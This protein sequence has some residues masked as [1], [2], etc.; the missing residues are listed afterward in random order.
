M[1]AK[2]IL[3]NCLSDILKIEGNTTEIKIASKFI[4]LPCVPTKGMW[5]N[6]KS[7]KKELNLTKKEIKLIE[8]LDWFTITEIII[9]YSFIELLITYGTDNSE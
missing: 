2:L 3:N 5:F 8:E 4:T 6:L 9:N 1:R 7:F